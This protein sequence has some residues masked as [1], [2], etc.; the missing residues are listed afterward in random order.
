VAELVSRPGFSLRRKGLGLRLLLLKTK[1]LVL[2]L[3]SRSI[4]TVPVLP[5]IYAARYSAMILYANSPP[6]PAWPEAKPVGRQSPALSDRPPALAGGGEAA[7]RGD[8]AW[9]ISF[10]KKIRSLP[11]EQGV[12]QKKN[13]AG[14]PGFFI[15][16]V[17]CEPEPQTR[18]V[19]RVIGCGLHHSTAR[20]RLGRRTPL[21]RLDFKR[22]WRSCM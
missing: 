7:G 4:E 16:R 13:R 21:A 9:S 14:W 2:C 3:E 10:P 22:E 17:G 18:A 20:N 11:T 5:T 15:R 19:F 6:S 12:A 8:L 1:S